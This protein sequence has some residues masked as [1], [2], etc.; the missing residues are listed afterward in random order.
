MHFMFTRAAAPANVNG[1]VWP[2]PHEG[3]AGRGSASLAAGL[4]PVV[5][6]TG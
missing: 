2:E 5:S 1:C 3:H 6:A 4:P